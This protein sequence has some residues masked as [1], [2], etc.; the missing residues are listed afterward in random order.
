MYNSFIFFLAFLVWNLNYA[1]CNT[2]SYNNTTKHMC[3]FHYN[4]KNENKKKKNKNKNL[5][6]TWRSYQSVQQLICLITSCFT[7]QYS[8]DYWIIR[9]S[10]E[11][12]CTY[13]TIAFLIQ[14][15]TKYNQHIYWKLACFWEYEL[16]VFL[17]Q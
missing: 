13:P 2:D 15:K 1:R 10:R 4:L 6:A 16:S 5:D 17:G 14:E 8:S 11:A 3:N 9:A 12:W 7:V